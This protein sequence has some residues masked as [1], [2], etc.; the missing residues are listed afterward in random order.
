VVFS[1]PALGQLTGCPLALQS[2]QLHGQA[3]RRKQ[4]STSA[5][6]DIMVLLRQLGH[7]ST[8]EQLVPFHSH[9]TFVIVI[10]TLNLHQLSFKD[11]R[12]TT[13]SS[14][15]CRQQRSTPPL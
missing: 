9:I 2:W 5:M 15:Q 1:W 7:A 11:Q 13:C 12:G 3:Q 6:S 10:I 14:R 8:W 4:R